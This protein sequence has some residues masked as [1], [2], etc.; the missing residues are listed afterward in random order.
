MDKID[1]GLKI[2]EFWKMIHKMY[3]IN[4]NVPTVPSPGAVA[5]ESDKYVKLSGSLADGFIIT[6]KSGIITMNWTFDILRHQQYPSY[7]DQSQLEFL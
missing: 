5:V 7:Q 1:I 3:P 4:I 2:D 6:L